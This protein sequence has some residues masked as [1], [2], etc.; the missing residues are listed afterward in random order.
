MICPDEA[1]AD[2]ALA[3]AE[4]LEELDLLACDCG[5]AFAVIGLPDHVDDPSAEIL[6][7]SFTAPGL[8]VLA[9]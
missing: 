3:E 7:V 9:A 4:T 1:C 2:E 6:V 8:S 5:C